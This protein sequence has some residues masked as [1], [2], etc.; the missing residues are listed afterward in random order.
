M[1]CIGGRFAEI[2]IRTAL[3]G[4]WAQFVEKLDETSG[5]DLKHGSGDQ[6]A[7]EWLQALSERLRRFEYGEEID[8]ATVVESVIALSIL[9][10]DDHQ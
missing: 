7:L 10:P 1:V 2:Q 6:Q 3:Q 4:L 5:S 8:W 9:R